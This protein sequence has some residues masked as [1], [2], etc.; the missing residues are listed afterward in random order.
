VPLQTRRGVLRFISTHMYADDIALLAVHPSG[1]QQ[2]ID[3]MS[4]CTYTGLRISLASGPLVTR[5]SALD[6]S[7]RP[8][9]GN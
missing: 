5:G 8:D 2:L 7:F 3:N 1:L 4:F 9:V 6:W